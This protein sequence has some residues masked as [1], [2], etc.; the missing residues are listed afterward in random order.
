MKSKFFLLIMPVLFMALF[1]NCKKDESAVRKPVLTV[2][3]CDSLPAE[4]GTFNIAYSVENPAEKGWE[5]MS[6][7]ETEAWISSCT[8]TSENIVISVEEFTDENAKSRSSQMQINYP[9]ADPVIM[10]IIQKAPEKEEIK[11]VTFTLGYDNLSISSVTADCMPSD[12]NATYVLRIVEKAEFESFQNDTEF[13]KNDIST[14][15]ASGNIEDHLLKGETADKEFTISKTNTEYYLIAYGLNADETITSDGITKTGFTSPEKPEVSITWDDETMIGAEGGDYEIEYTISNPV[16]GQK[17]EAE[18]DVQWISITEVTGNAIRFTVS[19]NDSEPG[20]EP[21]TGTITT[22]YEG[23]EGCPVATVKQESEKKAQLTFDISVVTLTPSSVT[24]NLTPSDNEATYVLY[25]MTKS[26]Y[27]SYASEADIIADDIKRFTAEDWWGEPG[28]IEENLL[29]GAQTEYYEY[30]NYAET[31]YYIIAYG[32]DADGTVTTDAMTKYEFRTPAKARIII[33]WDNE[34]ILPVEGGDYEATFEIQNPV[35]G[36]TLTVS[37][38]YYCS[39]W[40]QNVR[41]EG[42]KIKFTVSSSASET[43]GGTREGFLTFSYPELES[44]PTLSFKQ[45][46]PE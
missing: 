5:K 38:G 8:F 15:K 13:I 4:G 45:E 7:S 43:G 34:T 46:I 21:R 14:F 40:V 31:D 10:E 27:E 9:D 18:S 44:Y 39:D 30:L 42:D 35:D 1:S 24:F 36:A 16:D 41:I 22:S 17:L 33:D 20:S 23:A 28:T 6:V 12:L 3:K 19:A 11:P 37:A 29:K 2:A 26:D 32:L 25:T